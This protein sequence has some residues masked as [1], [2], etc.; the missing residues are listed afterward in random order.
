MQFCQTSNKQGHEFLPLLKKRRE[1]NI[2]KFMIQ[3]KN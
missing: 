3:K 2:T 1:K